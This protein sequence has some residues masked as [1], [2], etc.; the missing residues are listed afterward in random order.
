MPDKTL[1]EVM[2]EH[3]ASKMPTRPQRCT[4]CRWR[5]D[6]CTL[7]T[8]FEPAVDSPLRLDR[9]DVGDLLAKDD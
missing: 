3:E 1:Y 8:L 4:G 6:E 2:A 9:I 7:C 5:R